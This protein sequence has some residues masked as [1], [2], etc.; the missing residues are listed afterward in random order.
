MSPLTT[1]SARQR[2]PLLAEVVRGLAGSGQAQLDH[3]NY[4]IIQAAV[5][6]V[7]WPRTEL[8]Q[9]LASPE[10]TDPLLALLI[11]VGLTL[12]YYSLRAGAEEILLPGQNS[13]R[14]WVLSTPV[15]LGRILSGYL[16]G[17][18]LQTLHAIALSSPLLLMAFYVSGNTWAGFAWSL[19]AI[20]FQAT[21]FRLVGAVAYMTIGHYGVATFLIVR[22]ALL[23]VYVLSAALFPVM[24]HVAVS[25]HLLDGDYSMHLS[26][27]LLYAVLSGL[28]V[29]ALY[30]QLSRQRQLLCGSVSPNPAIQ[31]K[32][33]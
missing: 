15:R 7:W 33:R 26:F 9:V 10:R 25:S 14:E 20:V 27:L 29:I 18:L 17:Q 22:A 23:S 8:F 5:L 32:T 11:A 6:F 3:L 4:L 30:V 1:E 2:N 28:L 21:F 24:S 12:A 13:L 19:T 31:G 16:G